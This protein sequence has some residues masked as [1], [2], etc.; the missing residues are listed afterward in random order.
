MKLKDV[1]KFIFES[2]I[3]VE[4]GLT[5]LKKGQLLSEEEYIKSQEKIW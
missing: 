3:V 5:E 1:E 2:F 4:P